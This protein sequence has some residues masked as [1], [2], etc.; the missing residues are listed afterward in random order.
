MGEG[1]Q[2]RAVCCETH[3]KVPLT[4]C[5]DENSWVEMR[6]DLRIGAKIRC[7]FSLHVLLLLLLLL[8][9]VL[10]IFEFLCVCLLLLFVVLL[11]GALS[12]YLP[13]GFLEHICLLVMLWKIFAKVC[14][15]ERSWTSFS[16]FFPLFLVTC[17]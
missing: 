5:K 15:R 9:L 7:P 4:F 2:G 3:T 8:L 6:N 13:R 16:G 1:G 10:V 14:V 12:R 11:L 17:T